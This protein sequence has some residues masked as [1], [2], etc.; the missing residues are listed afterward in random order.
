LLDGLGE[1][2]GNRCSLNGL[3]RS[4]G[5]L[6]HQDSPLGRE[7]VRRTNRFRRI[8]ARYDKLVERFAFLVAAAVKWFA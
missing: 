2:F 1:S 5:G 3:G 8:A 7:L 6:E 4:R